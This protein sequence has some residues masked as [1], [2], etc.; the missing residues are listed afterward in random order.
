MASPKRHAGF[1]TVVQ[2]SKLLSL[3][4]SFAHPPVNP[5]GN[6]SL[7]LDLLS[8]HLH[9]LSS[10]ATQHPPLL[11]RT[12]SPYLFATTPVPPHPTPASLSPLAFSSPPLFFPFSI[13][14]KLFPPSILSSPSPASS[15]PSSSRPC[16]AQGAPYSSD[17]PLRRPLFPYLFCSTLFHIPCSSP[18]SPP[19]LP[20]FPSSS[21]PCFSPDLNSH[22]LSPSSPA[23]PRSSLRFLSLAQLRARSFPYLMLWPSQPRR[24]YTDP[25]PPA[26]F[27]VA[28]NSPSLSISRPVK[29]PI[30]LHAPTLPPP[31]LLTLTNDSR[32]IPHLFPS[33]HPSSQLSRVRCPPLTPHHSFRNAST[34]FFPPTPPPYQPF[35][36]FHRTPLPNLLAN[37]FSSPHVAAFSLLPLHQPTPPTALPRERVLLPP[38]LRPPSAFH[39]AGDSIHRTSRTQNPLPHLHPP[40]TVDL[41]PLRPPPP[42][43]WPRS[44]P[45]P[46]QSELKT[47]NIPRR[48]SVTS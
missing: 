45:N 4:N 17:R 1:A 2:C 23:S 31:P 37:P 38:Q 44:A 39:G 22:Q 33:F 13:S 41:L 42:T 30:F 48:A 14:L 47:R 46:I 28:A 21:I 27:F 11:S 43:C 3:G 15:F 7:S 5:H 8:I 26:T 16:L 24:Y 32:P 20:F 12:L 18:I 36:A 34:A 19:P 35:S 9:Y 29:H 40:P 10:L 6:I 25:A